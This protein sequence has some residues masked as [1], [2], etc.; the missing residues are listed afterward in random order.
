MGPFWKTGC[1]G[2]AGPA[3]CL[4]H[5]SH[6][7]PLGFFCPSPVPL[8]R[9]CVGSPKHR[10]S[11]A[12]FGELPGIAYAWLCRCRAL[13]G[14][15]GTPENNSH[16][17]R[18]RTGPNL[19]QHSPHGRAHPSLGST[20]H[21]AASELAADGASSTKAMVSELGTHPLHHLAKI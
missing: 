2:N 18:H 9:A 19:P 16:P 21:A 10:V 3:S 1:E 15:A 13:P 5:P 11:S 6:L 14:T 17:C 8:G 7:S 12:R 20:G 4:P